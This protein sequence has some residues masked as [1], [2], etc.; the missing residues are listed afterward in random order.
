[1]DY[2][3]SLIRRL[4]FEPSSLWRAEQA[5]GEEHFGWTQDT[6]LLAK[7]LDAAHTQLKGK[8]LRE[9]ERVKLPETNSVQE[10]KPNSVAEIDFSVLFQG[11]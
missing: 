10:Y 5:G 11:H 8:K 2:L 4:R 3:F 6:Y 1:M 9:S 7:L